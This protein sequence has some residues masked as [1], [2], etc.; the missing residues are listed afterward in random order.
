MQLADMS[1]LHSLQQKLCHVTLQH[2]HELI[3]ILIT[4]KHPIHL[5][6]FTSGVRFN[7]LPSVP[8]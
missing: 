6:G 3:F 8:C 4:Y 7:L 2:T 1:I 5:E